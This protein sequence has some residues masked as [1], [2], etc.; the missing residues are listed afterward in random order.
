MYILKISAKRTVKIKNHSI[1]YRNEKC[2]E[3]PSDK[4]KKVDAKIFKNISGH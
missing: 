2:I 1:K 4:Y 3:L